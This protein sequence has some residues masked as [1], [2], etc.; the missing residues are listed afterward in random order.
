M[1]E[2]I[3][4][5]ETLAK[6]LKNLAEEMV[7]E[8]FELQNHF[9]GT[10]SGGIDP[11]MIM[12]SI[13]S[14]IETDRTIKVTIAWNYPSTCGLSDVR[15]H[16]SGWEWIRKSVFV[17]TPD[18]ELKLE[19]GELFDVDAAKFWGEDY[20]IADFFNKYHLVNSLGYNPVYPF[21]D[22]EFELS[23]DDVANSPF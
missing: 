6:V 9:I 18:W 17:L 21:M 16:V 11:P 7:S 15:Y 23:D 3:R 22:E 4:E 12:R 20:R 19:G 13:S 10:N 2:K 14:V 1:S 5:Y 8:A